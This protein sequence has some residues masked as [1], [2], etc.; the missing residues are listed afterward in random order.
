MLR[1]QTYAGSAVP[2]QE[3]LSE[4]HCSLFGEIPSA[5]AILSND[6]LGGA[7]VFDGQIWREFDLVAL[8]D[9]INQG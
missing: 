7:V 6:D 3:M 4:K 5:G 2:N 8:Q 1:F 9:S